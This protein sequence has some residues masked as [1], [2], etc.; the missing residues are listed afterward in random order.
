MKWLS[1][2][3]HENGS[4]RLQPLELE[5]GAVVEV[6]GDQAVAADE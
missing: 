6:K 3:P 5:L 1:R 2:D 4:R